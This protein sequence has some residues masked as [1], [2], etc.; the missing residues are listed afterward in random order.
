MKRDSTRND[1]GPTTDGQ[2]PDP[3]RRRLLKS[4]TATAVAAGVGGIVAGAPSLIRAQ[5]GGTQLTFAFGPDDSGT[6]QTLIDD[7]NSSN[8]EGIE[9]TWREMARESDAYYRQLVS[10]FNVGATEI[11]VFGADVVW[12]PEFA[13][14]YWVQNLSG[15]FQSEFE[16]NAFLQAPL[17]SARHRDRIWG[18]PWYT[19]AGMLFYRRDLLEENGISEPPAT[20]QALSDAAQQVR[21]AAGIEHGFV[22]QG[23]RY[24]GG[25]TNMLEYVWN[26]GG[27]VLTGNIEN[28]AV[29]GMSVRD[30]NVITIDTQASAAGLDAARQLVESGVAPEAV[31]EFREQDAADA[32]LSGNAVF[33][34][35]WPF[36][37]GLF[38]QEGVSLSQEQVGVAPIPTGPGENRQSYS[39]LGGWNL[40][41]SAFSA[42]QEAAWSFI[43]YAAAEAQQRTRAENGGFLPTLSS[44]YDDQSLTEAVPVLGLGRDAIRNARVRPETPFY[45]DMSQRMAIAFNRVLL[46]E[47]SGEEAAS[48]LQDEL[49][50]VLRRRS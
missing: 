23:G 31:T 35:N 44:L 49:Q 27:R 9:V 21:D 24:E 32:F 42:N 13:T 45:A 14:Q 16:A 37:Y 25:V 12:T 26:A 47:L 19:D 36:V 6:L 8:D 38:G 11:D 3:T 28:A 43:R 41:I 17:R 46:G 1:V 39:C 20:W 30:A 2:L 50:A 10:D 5:G 29:P 15:L 7:F 4:A 40:M 22:F 33:M 34:R 48:R 18:V